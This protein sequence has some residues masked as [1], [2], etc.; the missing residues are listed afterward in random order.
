MSN[1]NDVVV[2]VEIN[3]EVVNEVEALFSDVESYLSPYKVASF[4][5]ILMGKKINPQMMYNYAKHNMLQTSLNSTNKLQVSKDEA[6]RFCIKFVSKN[7][8]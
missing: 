3:D 6:I 8:K 1:S 2:V 7:R 5:S 4:V